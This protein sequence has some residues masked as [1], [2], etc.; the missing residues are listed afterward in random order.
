MIKLSK[1]IL[2][3]N[4]T[5]RI[6][7]EELMTCDWL[8]KK[9]VTDEA[10]STNS[11]KRIKLSVNSGYAGSFSQPANLIE[12]ELPEENEQDPHLNLLVPRNKAPSTSQP[13][14]SE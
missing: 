9:K 4:P 11:S 5:K 7:L 10:F 2:E 13:M 3:D 6:T 8:R 14:T 12:Q 1:R